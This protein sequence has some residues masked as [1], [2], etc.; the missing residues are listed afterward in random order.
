MYEVFFNKTFNRILVT[1]FGGSEAGER[2]LLFLVYKQCV[3]LDGTADRELLYE[4]L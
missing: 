3:L 2:V 4:T 1:L